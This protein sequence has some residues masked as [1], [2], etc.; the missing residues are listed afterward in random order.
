MGEYVNVFKKHERIFQVNAEKD[1]L[2]V[3]L[4]FWNSSEWSSF[5]QASVKAQ[6]P[7]LKKIFTFHEK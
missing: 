6:V 1:P 4:W 2:Q 5:T 3:P 7:L